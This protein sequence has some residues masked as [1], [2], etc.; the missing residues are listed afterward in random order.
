MKIG[1][2]LPTTIPGVTRVQV[3]EW[4]KRADA[5]G[6]SCLGTIDRLVYPNW[7][8]LVGLGAAAAVTERIELTT[9][10]LLA[11]PRESAAVIAKQGATIHVLSGGRFVLGTAPGG[12]DDD[13]E[14]FGVST[15]GRGKRLD[16]MLDLIKRLWAGEEVGYA[17]GVGPDVSAKPPSII[18]GGQADAAFRRAAKYGDGWMMGG[19]PPERFG[20]ARAKLEA[21]FRDA[22]RK[23]TPRAMSLTYF[24][25]DDD[26]EAQA[27]STLG[28]YYSFIGEYAEVIVAG[29][30]KGVDEVRERIKGF[31]Q[32]GCDELIM[33][34]ASS[35]PAQVDKLAA[36]V[37]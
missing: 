10:V 15:K 35:D 24:S 1:I 8:S 29:T 3:I 25:L 7:D 4:S 32:Q 30:A 6:F 23:E 5:A 19:G 33:F 26:P 28:D 14:P 9:S 34:P 21:A 18:V 17:G 2:G 20:E 36:A 16:E 37:L 12:R 27:R 11:P 22:G 31:E 13:Y